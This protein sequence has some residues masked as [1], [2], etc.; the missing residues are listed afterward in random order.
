MTATI[1]PSGRLHRGRTTWLMYGALGL[2]TT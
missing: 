2:S 1:A